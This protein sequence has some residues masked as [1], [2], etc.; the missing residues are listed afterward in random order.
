M[1]Y[2]N[3][4]ALSFTTQYA[5]SR[6]LAEKQGVFFKF[7]MSRYECYKVLDTCGMRKNKQNCSLLKHKLVGRK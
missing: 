3:L 1:N 2:I 6:K 5:I 7:L 4:I